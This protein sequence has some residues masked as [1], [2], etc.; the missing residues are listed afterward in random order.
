MKEFERILIPTDGSESALF[1]V[2][3]GISLAKL[4]KVSAHAI[5]VVDTAAFASVPPD[6][7]IVDLESILESE[8]RR[9]LEKVRDMAK[10]AS[11]EL[12]TH[13]FKGRPADEIADF[14]TKNDLIVISTR[15]KTRLGRLFLGSVTEDVVHHA[16]CPVMVIRKPE[17]KKE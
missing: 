1:A 10:N 7:L 15:G 13:I 5:Y 3:K 14:A 6:S 16:P 12:H 11:V 2:E 8:A 17:D 9:I 4:L